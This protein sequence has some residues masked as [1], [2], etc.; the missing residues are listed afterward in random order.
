MIAAAVQS[1]P[2][3]P[4]CVCAQATARSA[5]DSTPWIVGMTDEK[6]RM[7]ICF[8]LLAKEVQIVYYESNMNTLN[9]LLQLG[10]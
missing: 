6:M 10:V 1:S 3:D 7:S 8:H 9:L 2:V 4:G 5:I